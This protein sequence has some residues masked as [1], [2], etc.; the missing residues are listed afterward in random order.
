MYTNG[1][2]PSLPAFV[3]NFSVADDNNNGSFAAAVFT[4]NC[5]VGVEET[6]LFACSDAEVLLN[7]TCSGEAAAIVKRQCPVSKRVCNVVDMRDLSVANTDYCEASQSTGNT[8]VCKCGLSTN[9]NSSSAGTDV[10]GDTGVKDQVSVAVMTEYITGDFSSTLSI[11]GSVSSN[12]AAGNSTLVY[13]TFGLLWGIGLVFLGFHFYYHHKLKVSAK[14][15]LPEH[16]RR[17]SSVAPLISNSKIVMTPREQCRKK[18]HNYIIAVIPTVF[19]PKPW[20]QRIWHEFCYHHDHIRVIISALG[21]YGKQEEEKEEREVK[22]TRLEVAQLLTS[23]TM[24]CFLLAMLYDLQY[25][26]N[27]GSCGLFKDETSCLTRKS[28]LDPTQSFCMWI[29]FVNKTAGVF[30][31]IKHWIMLQQ[32]P[33]NTVED[34]KV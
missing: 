21:L 1:S 17:R 5:T 13:V 29:P 34:E 8:V 32:L 27:D 25:P 7:L 26:N 12:T 24:A 14:S 16:L 10:A 20:L 15:K 6:V 4:H 23:I 19:H 2:Q 11:S 22:K 31:D 3:A 18:L 28:V 33:F 9:K 30:F